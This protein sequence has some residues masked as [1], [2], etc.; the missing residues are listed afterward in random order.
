[1]KCARIPL[2]YSL[3]ALFSSL[4]LWVIFSGKQKGFVC[5]VPVLCLTMMLQDYMFSVQP[6]GVSLC[7]HKSEAVSSLQR[8]R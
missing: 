8:C 4:L 6:L 2:Q 1:M 7:G 5:D 3:F